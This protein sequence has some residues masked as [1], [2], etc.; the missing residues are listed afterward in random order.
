MARSRQ[1]WTIFNLD[2]IFGSLHH[3]HLCLAIIIMIADCLK[4]N[5]VL[6]GVTSFLKYGTLD[7]SNSDVSTTTWVEN[8]THQSFW[9]ADMGCKKILQGPLQ[10][11]D[12]WVADNR[13]VR[14]TV[15]WL[16]GGWKL[17]PVEC[18]WFVLQDLLFPKPGSTSIFMN[19][20]C[21]QVDRTSQVPQPTWF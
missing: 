8:T 10:G 2:D 14:R 20:V 4:T 21:L 1:S 5:A 11:C 9:V 16:S 3:Q 19:I 12:F 17:L 6:D 18:E 7:T 13:G 15:L